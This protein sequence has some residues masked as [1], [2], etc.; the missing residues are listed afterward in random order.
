MA[1]RIAR[2]PDGPSSL[3]LQAEFRVRPPPARSALETV[4]RLSSFRGQKVLSSPRKREK[5]RHDMLCSIATASSPRPGLIRAPNWY[6]R[7][8]LHTVQVALTKP[9]SAFLQIG[10][11]PGAVLAF[12]RLSRGRDVHYGVSQFCV[13]EMSPFCSFL[14]LCQRAASAHCAAVANALGKGLPD[15]P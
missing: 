9:E 2:V 11:S 8:G 12:R 14:T 13:E 1:V 4:W 15:T 7:S 10:F 3:A 6:T 5:K